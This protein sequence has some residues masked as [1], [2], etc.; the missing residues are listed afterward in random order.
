VDGDGVIVLETIADLVRLGEL[1]AV[2]V[3]LDDFVKL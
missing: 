3:I 2:S 1:E